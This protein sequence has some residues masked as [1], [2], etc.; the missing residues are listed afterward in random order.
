MALG[1]SANA[2]QLTGAQTT[3]ISQAEY[4]DKRLLE[5]IKLESSNF[6]FSQLGREVEIPKNQGTTTMSVARYKHLPVGDHAL[7]E[8]VAPTPLQ[9]EGVKVQMTLEQYGAYMEITDWVA[10][11]HMHD[12]KS[13]Y[14]PELS[15]HAAEVKERNVI[16]ALAD[17]SE[18][19]VGGNTSAD[20]YA[21]GDTDYL[22]LEDLRRVALFMK[23]Y[24]RKGHR[25]FGG[26]FVAVMHTNVMQDL[27]DDDDLKDRLLVPGNENTP[28]KNGTLA[29]YTAYGMNFVE[30]LIAP[31]ATNGNASPVNVY[32]SY[33]LGYDPYVIT[34][35]GAGG[36]QWKMTGFE[37]EK[38]DPLGQSATFGYK[39]WTGAKVIDPL[40]IVQ[41]YS[42]SN[43]DVSSVVI[44]PAEVYTDDNTDELGSAASQA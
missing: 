19:Y 10:D 30:T 44:D 29:Q 9:P 37:A 31:V 22:T 36:V 34:K 20:D 8:G 38:S 33:V 28:I 21:A 40:A 26:R 14:Q 2:T 1:A 24:N 13:V 16:A 6:I 23:N 11:I 12:I 18:Y 42:V 15:R 4:W 5:M 43:F 41:V 39:L 3:N 17:G 27:L 7:S 32:T 35:L 25:K